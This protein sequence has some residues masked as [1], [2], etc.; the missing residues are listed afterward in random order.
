MRKCALA[1][2]LGLVVTAAQAQ[3]FPIVRDWTGFYAGGNVGGGWGHNSADYVGNDAGTSTLFLKG[4]KPPPAS[5]NSS[6]MLGG[7]HAGYNWQHDARW[8]VGIEADFSFANVR[9]SASGSAMIIDA[10][11]P[12]TATLD[13]RLKYLGTMRARMG[14][15]PSPNLLLFATGGLAYAEVERSGSYTMT[16]GAVIGFDAAP[17]ALCYAGASCFAGA[18]SAWTGGW[19]LGGGL[20]FALS[21]NWTVKA[22]YLHVSLGSRSVTETA[23]AEYPNIP[24]FATFDATSKRTN[25]DIT[26]IGASY[27]F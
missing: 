7:V 2:A 10:S 4:G 13:D 11:R 15:L 21:S 27:R 8:L 19:T 1:I 16:S 18:K 12:V 14:Y 20:E 24:G 22:E 3:S 17:S 9:G 5:L 23:T 26:R 6:G 25:L